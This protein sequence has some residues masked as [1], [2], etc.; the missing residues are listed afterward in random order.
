[1]TAKPSAP[2]T[3]RPPDT[4]MAASVSSGR[5]PL[6][7]AVC[8]VTV[9]FVAA[10]DS[11]TDTSVRA[12][13]VAAATGAVEFGRTVK[14]GVPRVT[15]EWTTVLPPNTDCVATSSALTATASVM[16][17]LSVRTASRPATSLPSAE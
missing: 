3:P 9:A 7:A 15:E 16:T 2:P 10:S 4:T 12:G 14:I 13:V 17:P 6:V 8:P 1:M 11:V 5:P